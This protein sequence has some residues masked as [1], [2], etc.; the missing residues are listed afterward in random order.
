MGKA[1]H[2]YSFYNI[3]SFTFYFTQNLHCV[4][5]LTQVEPLITMVCIATI[6]RRER[7]N[8]V[9]THITDI[10]AQLRNIHIATLL[11]PS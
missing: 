2:L 3:V 9:T 5:Y 11:R 7:D 10:A 6:K 4:Y 8:R 1:N